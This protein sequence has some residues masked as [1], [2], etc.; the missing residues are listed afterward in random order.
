MII[1]YYCTSYIKEIKEQE[2]LD[3]SKED[4]KAIIFLI[5]LMI[6]IFIIGLLYIYDYSKKENQNNNDNKPTV[7]NDEKLNLDEAKSV[8]NV[9]NNSKKDSKTNYENIK[10]ISIKEYQEKL[11]N[12]EKMIVLIASKYCGSCSS[13]EPVFNK[14]LSLVKLKAYKIDVA[15]LTTEEK[16][17]FN[18]LFN[19]TGTPTTFI[20]ENGSQKASI[21]GY[22][23][24]EATTSWLNENY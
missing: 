18:S 23:S 22:R 20:I 21:I 19:I 10:E 1:T 5:G 16:N 12:N 15:T 2:T 3:D 4:N 8:N 17:L 6:I 7:I 13:F 24:K 9:E 11:N 14:S